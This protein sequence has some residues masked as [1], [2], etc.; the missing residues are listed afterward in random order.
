MYSLVLVC[1]LVLVC[2]LVLVCWVGSYCLYKSELDMK[3]GRER[4]ATWAGR[5]TALARSMSMSALQQRDLVFVLLYTGMTEREPSCGRAKRAF[6]AERRASSCARPRAIA[7][8][9]FSVCPA[10]CTGI[11]SKHP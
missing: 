3:R 8:T 9:A 10:T 1:R 2:S 4:K 6:S 7:S 11:F 5:A